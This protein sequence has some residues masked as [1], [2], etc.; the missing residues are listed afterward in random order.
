[1][2]AARWFVLVA[3]LLVL[4]GL[5]VRAIPIG[6]EAAS[7]GERATDSAAVNEIGLEATQFS[8]GA[9]FAAR[10]EAEAPIEA[11]IP[12]PP[13]PA[14]PQPPRLVGIATQNGEPVVWLQAG[15]GPALAL[16]Q[17]E[18]IAGWEVVSIS[19][20]DV[21]IENDGETVALRLFGERN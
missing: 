12:L 8:G 17:G 20:T 11:E 14:R 9:L 18:A 10:V 4:A 7:V 5:S 13:E 6:G 21:R 1:M 15:S 19:D 3:A 2:S 16:R